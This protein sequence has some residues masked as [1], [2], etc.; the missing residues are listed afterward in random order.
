MNCFSEDFIQK[1]VDGE[2]TESE[3]SMVENH[4]AECIE[5]KMSI[6]RQKQ[7]SI[8][9]KKALNELVDEIPEMPK[10][11]TFTNQGRQHVSFK[12]KLVYGMAA[13]CI[14]LLLIFVIGRQQT[15]NRNDMMLYH[16]LDFEVD[17][18][19]PI[20]DQEL[21]M[22]VIDENGNITKDENN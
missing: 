11:P 18:N 10:M 13:A 2:S 21:I 5:C 1:Y 15:N 6:E 16:S 7:R 17:A 12:R 3:A 8:K 4:T 9:L 14:L 19:K 20:T 22:Y